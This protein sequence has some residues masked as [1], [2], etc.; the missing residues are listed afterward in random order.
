MRGI[1]G[2]MSDINITILQAVKQCLQNVHV[3]FMLLH[4]DVYTVNCTRALEVKT[5][6]VSRSQ[7][8]NLRCVNA[9]T[10]SH[11][12]T[13]GRTSAGVLQP[14]PCHP[15]PCLRP[16]SRT[17]SSGRRPAAARSAIKHNTAQHNTLSIAEIVLRSNGTFSVLD[18][19]AHVQADS[20]IPLRT[21]LCPSQN[22]QL[23]RLHNMSKTCRAQNC[24]H[25]H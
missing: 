8:S 21:T 10:T 6:N 3:A 23:R 11:S 13:T 15:A 22:A 2:A 25:K 20:G 1:S 24:R 12:S 18:P 17:Q 19:D 7:N 4:A 9:Q 5:F 16:Q 14:L